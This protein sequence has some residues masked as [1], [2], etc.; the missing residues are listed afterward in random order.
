LIVLQDELIS[1]SKK[2]APLQTDLFTQP[3]DKHKTEIPLRLRLTDERKD[4]MLQTL[5]DKLAPFK[6][7]ST[8]NTTREKFA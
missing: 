2:H 7:V 1:L 4:Q 6:L 8:N 3:I 5:S